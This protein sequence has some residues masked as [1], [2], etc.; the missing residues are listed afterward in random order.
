MPTDAQFRAIA[1]SKLLDAIDDLRNQAEQGEIHALGYIAVHE[2]GENVVV[3]LT[4]GVLRSVT[5]LGASQVL[6]H[7]V[8]DVV[9]SGAGQEYTPP[10][11]EPDETAN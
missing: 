3:S 2:S 5:L 8:L 10:P 4:N 1:K 9:S 11:A 7:R 6:M